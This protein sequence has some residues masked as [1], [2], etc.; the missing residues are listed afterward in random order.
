MDDGAVF[1]GSRLQVQSKVVVDERI[2]GILNNGSMGH[3]EHTF[4]KFDGRFP[5]HLSKKQINEML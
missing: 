1:Q 5:G 4:H 3:S 2:T